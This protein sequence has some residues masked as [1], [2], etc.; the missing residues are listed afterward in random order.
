MNFRIAESLCVAG[1]PS[2]AVSQTD[3]DGEGEEG[4]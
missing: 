3:S 1:A 2:R 4:L